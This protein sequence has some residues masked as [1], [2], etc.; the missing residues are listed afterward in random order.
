VPA[1]LDWLA[2]SMTILIAVVTNTASKLV[3]AAVMGRGRFAAEVAAMT[4]LCW[5]A[6]A[7]GLWLAVS[8]GLAVPH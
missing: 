4:V 5:F 1:P 8:A 2:A 7:A 6:G 3:L